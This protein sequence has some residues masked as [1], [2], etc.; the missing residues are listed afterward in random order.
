MIYELHLKQNIKKN[1]FFDN[2][3][4]NLGSLKK[5]LRFEKLYKKLDEKKNIELTED[6]LKYKLSIVD[7]INILKKEIKKEENNNDIDYFLDTGNLLFKY[8]ENISNV[9]K[10]KNIIV[11]NIRDSNKS[12]SKSVMDYF[13]PKKDKKEEEIEESEEEEKEEYLSKSNIYDKYMSEN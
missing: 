4:E 6:E 11:N 13:N 5:L 3:R 10:G 9:E 1:Y 12:S 7:N 2:K 8:Y